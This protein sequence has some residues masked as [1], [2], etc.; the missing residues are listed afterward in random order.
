[1]NTSSMEENF[2]GMERDS[3]PCFLFAG[4]EID[5]FLLLSIRLHMHANSIMPQFYFTEEGNSQEA[6]K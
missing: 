5:A 6:W 4:P 1:M 3:P 2:W